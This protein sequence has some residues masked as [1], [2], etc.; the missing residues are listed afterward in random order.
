MSVKAKKKAKAAAGTKAAEPLAQS[1]P[2][3]TLFP[4]VWLLASYLA[5]AIVFFLPA[6]LPGR[7][8]FGTDYVAIS[9]IFEEFV[10]AR[11]AA[12]ELPSWMPYVYGGVP[13]FANPMD[14]YNPVTLLLRLLQVPTH[15]HL[16]WIFIIHFFIAG[17]GTYFLLREL[18]ARRMAAYLAG[19][20]FM[21]SG[22]I[23]SFIYAG[24]EGRAIVATLAPLFFFVMH[25]GI[26]TGSLKWFVAGGPVLGSALLS[27][28]IQS[29]YYLL[30]SGG[31]WSLF[32]LW[33]LGK[34]R[35][36]SVLGARLGGGIL[37]LAIG[38]SMAA[39]N[40][41]P[42]LGYVDESPRAGEEGRGYEYAVSWAKPPAEIVGLAVPERAGI[43][44]NYRGANPFKLHT[45]YAGAL[46]ILLVAMGVYMLRR[47]RYGWFFVGL[48]LFTLT[49]A[50]GGHTPLYRLY[51]EILPGTKRFRAP[52]ISFYLVILGLSVLAGLALEKLAVLRQRLLSRNPKERVTA[53]SEYRVVFGIG[54]VAIAFFLFWA[55]VISATLA[56]QTTPGTTEHA[57]DTA[58]INGLWRFVGFLLLTA[59]GLWLWLR[60]KVAQQTAT[61]MLGL[62][63]VADLWVINR[64]FLE[65]LPGPAVHFASHEI[66]D[67]LQEQAKDGPFRTWLVFDLPQDNYLTRFGLELLTGEHGNQLQSF[68]EFLGAGEDI[69]VDYHN[70]LGHEDHVVHPTF[71]SLANVRFVV[72]QNRMNLPFLRPVYQGRMPIVQ[73]LNRHYTTAVVY[74][75]TEVLPRSFLVPNASRV[76]E[77]DGALLQ[78]HDPD[79]DPLLEVLLYDEPPLETGQTGKAAG[80][81]HITSHEPSEVVLEVVAENPAYLV[82][83]DNYYEGW[84]AEVNGEPSPILRAYHT[85]RAV[86][87]PAGEHQVVFRFEPAPLRA[88]LV[89][90]SAVGLLLLA[91]GLG[92]G[93][94]EWSRRRKQA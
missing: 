74:E 28:Q 9:L 84:T 90:S 6:L 76:P 52:S 59:G 15:L 61:V 35:P 42:F 73:A 1:A 25:R 41:V 75:N 94:R 80:Y 65:T 56:G 38:F 82:L 58:Y 16:E 2:S 24:H 79:F 77:P 8:I 47:N 71:L 27:N 91:Y 49:I 88:G 72:T 13:F 44:E 40:F 12:G 31:I 45:E 43:L 70:L 7:M 81:A 37:V 10:T 62:I 66:P 54:F 46:A 23:I 29:A 67:F 30:L 17:A 60:G 69:Y 20:L 57:R 5:L 55:L 33:H 51:Y 39:I 86:T 21:F 53:E 78:M 68:N 4:T 63:A 83:T 87:V 19:L 22:Y 85:F 26:R 32:C 50:F 36:M 3:D 14:I 93:W 18:G 48:G 89:V 92:L 34:L 11:F 64:H